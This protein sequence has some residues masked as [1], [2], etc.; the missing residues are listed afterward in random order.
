MKARE[1]KA[2]IFLSSAIPALREREREREREVEEGKEGS[3]EERVVGLGGMKM[4]EYMN[5]VKLKLKLLCKI[6]HSRLEKGKGRH[7]L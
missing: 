2:A 6:Y 3:E 7:W 4:N 1:M 5:K